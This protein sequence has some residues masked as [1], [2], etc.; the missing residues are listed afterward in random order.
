MTS[1][2]LQSYSRV[3]ARLTLEW[4]SLERERRTVNGS[5]QPLPAVL[6]LVSSQEV[7]LQHLE[8]NNICFYIPAH[9]YAHTPLFH[10]CGEEGGGEEGGGEEGGGKEGGR[11]GG[12]E[13]GGG[14]REVGEGRREVGWRE[15]GGGRWEKGGGR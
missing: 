13:E 4:D 8:R 10:T 15:V 12:G 9:M 3:R 11:E 1:L 6:T 7:L 5:F 14:R 2:S